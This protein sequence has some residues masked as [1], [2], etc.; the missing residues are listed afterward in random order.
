MSRFQPV[1]RA[2]VQGRWACAVL[3]IRIIAGRSAGEPLRMPGTAVPRSSPAACSTLRTGMT[4]CPSATAPTKPN[5]SYTPRYRRI[6]RR[7]PP[8]GPCRPTPGGGVDPCAP[9]AGTRAGF[10][11][12]RCPPRQR[13][14]H[15]TASGRRAPPARRP[16]CLQRS[17]AGS[18]ALADCALPD[19]RVR[20]RR[21]LAHDP[22]RKVLSV[23]IARRCGHFPRTSAMSFTCSL[24]L[25]PVNNAVAESEQSQNSRWSECASSPRRAVGRAGRH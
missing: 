25:K 10:P 4:R 8:A 5:C 20:C 14:P 2:W 7:R 15:R 3:Y 6:R 9:D 19:P 21:L 13:P 24:L 22:I 11:R 18:N 1:C 12:H 17:A 16:V 23:S